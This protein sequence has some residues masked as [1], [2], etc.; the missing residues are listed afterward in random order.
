M[1]SEKTI[2]GRQA[3]IEAIEASKTISKVFIQRDINKN[4]AMLESL[5]GKTLPRGVVAPKSQ[6][7]TWL[8]LER[9]LKVM[10]MKG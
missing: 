10:P 3:I 4:G 9:I 1:Q 8:I 7:D 2:F 6:R 5:E